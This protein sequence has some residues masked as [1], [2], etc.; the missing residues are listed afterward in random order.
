MENT[1]ILDTDIFPVSGTVELFPQKGGWF[2][3]RVPKKYTEMTKDVADR[4]L[5]AIAA[6]VGA[7]TWK[8]SLLPM[9]DGTQF[10]ALPAKV[11]KQEHIQVGDSIQMSFVLR[12][13]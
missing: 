7:T 1:L 3:V 4:G 2:Y 9:G 8:T 11:R 13:R 10:I 12:N 5:V 6:T